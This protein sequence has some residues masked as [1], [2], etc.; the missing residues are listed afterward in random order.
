[1]KT[2]VDI[3]L[4][5]LMAEDLDV[6]INKNSKFGLNLEIDDERGEPLIREE[7]INVSAIASFADFCRSFLV[8][9]DNILKKEVA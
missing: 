5:D 3:T 4:Y 8:S 6:W 2:M 1:M 7:G 9:Y